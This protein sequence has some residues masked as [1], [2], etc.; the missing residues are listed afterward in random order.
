MD[1][2]THEALV[3]LGRGGASLG[4]GEIA[5]LAQSLQQLQ[6]PVSDEEASI[7]V[8][9]LD[10][11]ALSTVRWRLFELIESAP[12]WPLWPCLEHPTHPGIVELRLRLMAR[13]FRPME[14]G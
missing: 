1:T 14:M 2:R 11:P 4:V 8:E 3:E 12:G 13:G 9:A 10:M 6:L 5:R 7:L